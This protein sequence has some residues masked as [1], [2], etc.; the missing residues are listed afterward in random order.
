[1]W[2]TIYTYENMCT[3]ELFL[4]F[5][6]GIR[7]LHLDDRCLWHQYSSITYRP[8]LQ[9]HRILVFSN[10]LFKNIRKSKILSFKPPSFVILIYLIKHPT[11]SVRAKTNDR[12]F[13]TAKTFT[14]KWGHNS[15]SS[16][17]KWDV[18]RIMFA[19]YIIK[20]IDP[21]RVLVSSL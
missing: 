14:K 16:F 20:V 2:Y 12:P 3:S 18:L 7:K 15:P 19:K 10:I 4:T 11:V 6:E 17:V 1:M 13:V 21:R 9:Y 8:M 5:Y